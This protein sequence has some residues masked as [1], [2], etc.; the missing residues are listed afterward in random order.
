MAITVGITSNY[1]K[2][3]PMKNM[4]ND[5]LTTIIINM[6]NDYIILY[7]IMVYSVY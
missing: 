5:N 3:I 6:L 1:N 7:Y 4:V 2:S